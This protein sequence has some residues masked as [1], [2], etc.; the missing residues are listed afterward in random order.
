M[1]LIIEEINRAHRVCTRY[2]MEE[3]RATLGRCYDNAV[4]VEDPH[5]DPVHAEVLRDEDGCYLLRD[6][7]SLNG[8]RLL[9][10]FRDKSVKP[11]QVREHQIQSG[12]E[13]QI[14]KSH[15]RFIDTEMS[16]AP[17]IP[18]HTAETVFDR[19]A[20]PVVAVALCL[21]V[22]GLS[23][24]LAYLGSRSEFQWTK[25]VEILTNA[26]IGLL[27]YAG[28]WAFIGKVVKHESHFLAHLSIAA[29]AALAY[30]AWQWFSTL[31][32]FNFSLHA[33]MPL[34]NI[35]A[36]A[37]LVPVMLWCAAY[38][39]LNI[40]PHWRLLASILL[41]WSFLGFAT[42]V[43]IG[44]MAEFHDSPQV[45]KELKSKELLWRKPVPLD[46]FLADAP[47]LFDIPL[48]EEV[49]GSNKD[50]NKE[51]STGKGD[52]PSKSALSDNKLSAR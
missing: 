3:E 14:G 11:R 15:F 36:L 48:E 18:L 35:L 43:E 12:D 30:A 19:I 23:L 10:N 41:P 29:S 49:T 6:L 45:S 34:M 37:I 33:I 5:V 26:V 21:L 13:V 32:N 24:W 42:A 27:V 4:M 16:V 38:L 28:A 2:R 39:A 9:R 17:A 51:K 31:L 20:T 25:A 7:G 46:E 44:K 40:A 8:V 22:A 52:K 47:E 50:G 1:A